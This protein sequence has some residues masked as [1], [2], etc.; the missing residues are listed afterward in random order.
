MPN[1]CWSTLQKHSIAVIAASSATISLDSENASAV[2]HLI[3]LIKNTAFIYKV[4]FF[5]NVIFGLLAS[6]H[7]HQGNWMHEYK[8]REIPNV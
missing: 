2:V 5:P 1:I 6:N 7:E 4:F 3:S 8:L